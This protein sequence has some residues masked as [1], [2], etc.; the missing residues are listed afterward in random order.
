[1][2]NVFKLFGIIAIVTVIGF[3]ISCGGESDKD[4]G[5]NAIKGNTI[6]SELEVIYAPNIGNLSEAKSATDFGYYYHR[7][8]ENDTKPLSYFF[9]G[10]PS[11]TV[12]NSK[13]TM[14]LGTPKSAYL[15]NIFDYW[16]ES[17]T[18]NPSN[19]K[20]FQ[21]GNFC[22]SDK[23]YSLICMKSTTTYT[24]SCYLFYVDRDVTLNSTDHNTTWNTSLKEG[25][26]YL[27]ASYNENRVTYTSSTNNVKWYVFDN[28]AGE[29]IID[30]R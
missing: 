19:V 24:A 5:N 30:E 27:S 23:K 8:E 16:S 22:T 9:D 18:V 17:I 28:N 7:D 11:V 4:G 26:N 20:G 25:W 21:I 15:K 1:M 10:S 13:L 2:K 3:S 29:E 6:T 14:I 12:K